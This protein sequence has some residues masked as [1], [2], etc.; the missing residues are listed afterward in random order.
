MELFSVVL[1]TDFAVRLRAFRARGI[2][3]AHKQQAFTPLT[4]TI[5][6]DLDFFD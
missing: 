3:A 5:L 1:T 2:G 6:I 4:I